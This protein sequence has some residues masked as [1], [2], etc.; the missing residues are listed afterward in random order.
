M[1]PRR[2]PSSRAVIRRTGARANKP[3]SHK[4]T[5][6]ITHGKRVTRC[7]CGAPLTQRAQTD[8]GRVT[9]GM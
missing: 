4:T 7:R 9:T 3:I 5:N 8:E 6:G 2:S 1:R